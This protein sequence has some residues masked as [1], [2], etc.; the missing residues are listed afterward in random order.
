MAVIEAAHLADL[1]DE[2]AGDDGGLVGGEE[3]HGLQAVVGYGPS[4]AVTNRE[5]SRPS[6]NPS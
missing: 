5:M 1:A 2:I 4:N 3:E 6:T